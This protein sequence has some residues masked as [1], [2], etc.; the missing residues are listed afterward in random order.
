MPLLHKMV[1]VFLAINLGEKCYKKLRHT[2]LEMDVN[3]DGVIT[4]DE[5]I[6]FFESERDDEEMQNVREIFDS[7][8]LNKN[9]VLEYSEFIAANLRMH[10]RKKM[11]PSEEEIEESKE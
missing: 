10:I 3:K 2:F 7:I 8:D 11:F 5:M 1:M 9:G 4:L 6:D